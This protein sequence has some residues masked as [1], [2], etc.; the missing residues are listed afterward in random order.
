MCRDILEKL[1]R[2]KVCE[3]PFSGTLLNTYIYTYIHTDRQT[4]MAKL[5]GVYLLLFIAKASRLFMHSLC[6]HLFLLYT[7]QFCFS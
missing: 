3:N 1:P 6:I 4:N 5:I 7:L 2:I